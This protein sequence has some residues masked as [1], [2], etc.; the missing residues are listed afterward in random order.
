MNNQHRVFVFGLLLFIRGVRIS[1]STTTTTTTTTTTATSVTTTTT[2]T[3]TTTT[4]TTSTTTTTASVTATTTT[5]NSELSETPIPITECERNTGQ[6]QTLNSIASCKKKK[7]R[8]G[9]CFCFMDACLEAARH[10]HVQQCFYDTLEGN[11]KKEVVVANITSE[12]KTDDYQT[13][14]EILDEMFGLNGSEKTTKKEGTTVTTVT[15]PTPHLLDIKK[16]MHE[17]GLDGGAQGELP[18]GQTGVVFGDHLTL[19]NCS[20]ELPEKGLMKILMKNRYWTG[21]YADK[22]TSAYKELEGIVEKELQI[23]MGFSP[24]Q[25]SQ[26]RDGKQAKHKIEVEV[27]RFTGQGRYT[28]VDVKINLTESHFDNALRLESNFRVLAEKYKAWNGTGVFNKTFKGYS[29]HDYDP[30]LIAAWRILPEEA[31][32][33]KPIVVLETDSDPLEKIRLDLDSIFA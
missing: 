32:K 13:Y 8:E 23:L 22:K 9:T 27:E 3:S 10:I 30:K 20:A 19:C 1:T 4:S 11:E 7:Y 12:N 18:A 29:K 14:D 24:I 6:V 21:L 33:A 2:T 5:K 31:A 28:A 16:Y 17:H 26:G 15:T 25:V